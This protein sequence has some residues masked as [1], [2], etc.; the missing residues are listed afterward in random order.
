MQFERKIRK[1]GETSLA[2]VIPA[3]LASY[4]DLQPEDDIVIQDE[5]GKKGKFLSM[6]KKD[7]SK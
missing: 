6:W 4:L 5:Q 7:S 3:D 1:W 2:F